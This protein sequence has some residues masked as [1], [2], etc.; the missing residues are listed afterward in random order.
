[1]YIEAQDGDMWSN[2]T[3]LLRLA[4]IVPLKTV[5]TL[6][7]CY[8]VDKSNPDVI[9]RCSSIVHNENESKVQPVVK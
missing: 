5:P 8:Q 6:R 9:V 4:E 7:I 2:K 3:K 1:M